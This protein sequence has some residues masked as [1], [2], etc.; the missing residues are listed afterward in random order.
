MRNWWPEV[1]FYNRKQRKTWFECI[2]Y[3]Y[4]LLV[5]LVQLT[6]HERVTS[7]DLTRSNYV[8]LSSFSVVIMNSSFTVL[9]RL[10]NDQSFNNLYLCGGSCSRRKWH[11]GS[12]VF[13]LRVNIWNHVT[14]KE[15]PDSKVYANRKL[16]ARTWLWMISLIGWNVDDRMY[17]D[18][19]WYR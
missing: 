14:K 15:R 6:W 7:N 16:S 1:E 5:L 19:R 18:A 3:S 8:T 2:K 4:K 12:S 9:T 10:Q 17:L 11:M 13:F